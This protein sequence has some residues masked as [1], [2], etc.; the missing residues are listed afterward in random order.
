MDGTGSIYLSLKQV[1]VTTI[2]CFDEVRQKSRCLKN[3]ISHFSNLYTK[4]IVMPLDQT[5]CFYRIFPLIIPTLLHIV[6]KKKVQ[7]ELYIYLSQIHVEEYALLIEIESQDYINLGTNNW[8]C[9]VVPKWEAF[10]A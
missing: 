3:L 5:D 1:S 10:Y 8:E 2:K 9:V 6:S 7:L 4:P